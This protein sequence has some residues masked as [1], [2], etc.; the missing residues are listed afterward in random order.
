MQRFSCAVAALVLSYGV[1][2][3]NASARHG[4][5]SIAPRFVDVASAAESF[6]DDEPETIIDVRPLSDY[7]AGHIE[8]A[9]HLDDA[10]LR[11]PRGRSPV[12]LLEVEALAALFGSIGVRHDT[13]V[14]VYGD[15]HDPLSATLVA[16]ALGRVGHGDVRLL[17]GGYD[18][19]SANHPVT[20]AF[21][22]VRPAELQAWPPTL[23]EVVFGQVYGSVRSGRT[24]F[25]DARPREHYLGDRSTWVRNG[26]I[27]GAVSVPWKSLTQAHNAH[28]LKSKD[29]ID[30]I[31]SSAGVTADDTIVVYC[32]TGREATLLMLTLVGEMGWSNVSLY[33][34]SWTEYSSVA[35]V[36]VEVGSGVGVGGGVGVGV[37]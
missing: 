22:L 11:G 25:I 19:W 18:A 23:D 6:V 28:R 3:P 5:R 12:R 17:A 24:V 9:M 27:P 7:L 20:R 13:P 35:G 15:R 14:F 10:A 34:G 29:E 36:G 16:Y 31:L 32:G 26:H 2:S 30:A 37:P 8:G 21:P 4:E 33:E 1:V